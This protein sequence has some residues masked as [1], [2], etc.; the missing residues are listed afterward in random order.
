MLTAAAA[1]AGG[2]FFTRPSPAWS[3]SFENGRSDIFSAWQ[4]QWT[5]RIFSEFSYVWNSDCQ[6]PWNALWWFCLMG[7]PC[8]NP[9]GPPFYCSM[10]ENGKM[11][12]EWGKTGSRIHMYELKQKLLPM[13]TWFMCHW[14]DEDI[15]I[16]EVNEWMLRA[17]VGFV[18]RGLS[19]SS[20]RWHCPAA[21]A[22]DGS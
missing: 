18:R 11:V 19:S 10:H 2:N 8:I 21:A 14:I 5:V 15:H 16:S 12:L 6:I 20:V 17:S 7:L 9:T 4:A 22:S 1:P 13:I 3:C